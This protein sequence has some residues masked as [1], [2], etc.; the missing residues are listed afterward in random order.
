MLPGASSTYRPWSV[1]VASALALTRIAPEASSV[2]LRSYPVTV[3]VD[4]GRHALAEEST[5]NS[6]ATFGPSA[7]SWEAGPRADEPDSD[8]GLARSLDRPL[9]HDADGFDLCL[10]HGAAGPDRT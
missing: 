8:L 5:R 2:A 3:T 9:R 1:T 6:C 10:V 4:V 7:V